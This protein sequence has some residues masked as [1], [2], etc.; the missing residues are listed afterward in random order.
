VSQCVGGLAGSLTG[1]CE[2]IPL[3]TQAQVERALQRSVWNEADEQAPRY[4]VLLCEN[5]GDFWDGAILSDLPIL[6]NDL[7]ALHPSFL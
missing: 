2:P 6:D 3:P 7:L 1:T 4:I 5:E